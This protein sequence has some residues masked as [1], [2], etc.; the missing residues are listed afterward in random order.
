MIFR[1]LWRIWFAL[2]AIAVAFCLLGSVWGPNLAITRFF[3]MAFNS[4]YVSYWFLALLIVIP[5]S[6]L[7][8]I[9]LILFDSSFSLASRVT[10][11][12]LLAGFSPLQIPLALYWFFRVELPQLR[13]RAA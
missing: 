6:S 9:A 3:P 13:S 7:C 2:T 1:K 10:W 5:I 8:G 4:A 11:A 12:V